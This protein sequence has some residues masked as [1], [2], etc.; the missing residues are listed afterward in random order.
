MT[1]DPSDPE[2]V[3]VVAQLD[4]LIGEMERAGEAG[5]IDQAMQLVQ[6]VDALERSREDMLGAR[7]KDMAADVSRKLRCD[8]WLAC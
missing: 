6:T 8:P 1:L 4:Q 5:D 2:L 7:K 3:R